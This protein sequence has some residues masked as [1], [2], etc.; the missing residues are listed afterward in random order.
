MSSA[1]PGLP[2]SEWITERL[3]HCERIVARREGVEREGWLA[4]AG[5]F[6]RALRA[7]RTHHDDGLRCQRCDAPHWL[8]T[9]IPSE[10]WNQIVDRREGKDDDWGLLCLLC[11]EELAAA[12]GLLCDVV[13]FYFVGAALRSRLYAESTGDIE[14]LERELAALHEESD[15]WA[16]I[17]ESHALTLGQLR[18]RAAHD[19]RRVVDLEQALAFRTKRPIPMLLFCPACGAQHV[20][21]P[22]PETGWDNPPHKSHTCHGCGTIWRPA[23]VETVGVAEITTRGEADTWSHDRPTT[24]YRCWNCKGVFT[25]E[26]AAE[27]FL[28]PHDA[29]P[30]C[31]PINILVEILGG[32]E[33]IIAEAASVPQEGG[34]EA[35]ILEQAEAVRDLIAPLIPPVTDAVEAPRDVRRGRREG[36][37]RYLT[38]DRD[39]RARNEL[40]FFR[41]GNGDLY[42]GVMPEGEAG[43]GCFVRICLSGGAAARNPKLVRAVFEAFKALGG[44]RD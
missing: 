4:D 18:N 7:I 21:A 38:D 23:D 44:E 30:A 41:G 27:H 10:I 17:A 25:E 37:V 28:L 13:E 39:Q 40:A 20:D 3:K 11:I 12:K 1:M 24:M 31:L 32:I 16:K 22:E 6:R 42:V 33:T 36:E 35:S 14:R 26:A 8:D 43:F 5:Y 15:D 9:S 2:L 34:H 29:G 19:E